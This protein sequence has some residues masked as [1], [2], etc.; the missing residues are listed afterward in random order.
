MKNKSGYSSAELLIAVVSLFLVAAAVFSIYLFIKKDERKITIVN[1]LV[2]KKIE[3][4]NLFT[5]E[6][7]FLNTV[8]A[9]VN[10]NMQCLRTNT[11]C[12][13]AYVGKESAPEND[14]IVLFDDH[15]NPFYD[16]RASNARG[17]TEDGTPCNEFKY[18]EPGND[19]CPIGYIISWHAEKP[20]TDAAG[21][22]LTITIKLV[23]NPSATHPEREN[24]RHLLDRAVSPYDL[25]FK[26]PLVAG[27]N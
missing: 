17:F 5:R 13:D 22:T 4:E 25:E 16:G 1:T 27:S 12:A 9:K 20:K 10:T 2:A 8:I 19:G 18:G 11:P 14:R 21:N 3:F 15:G 23:F 26:Q 6:E 7:T 24:I